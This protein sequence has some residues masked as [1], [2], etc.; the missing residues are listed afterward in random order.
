M[1]RTLRSVLWIALSVALLGVALIGA[2][3][4]RSLPVAD[5]VVELPG[6]ERNVA[7]ALD[8]FG[9]P[10][11]TAAGRTDAYRALGFMHA[12]DRLF[13]MD[14]A[15]RKSSGEL[16][17]LFGERALAMD[18][19]QRV[20][21]ARTAAAAILAA[22]P[23]DQRVILEAYA[24]GVNGLMAGSAAWPPE[25][26][27]LGYRPRPWRP[28]DSLL[29]GFGMFQTLT[30]QEQDER[31]LSVM[32]RTLPRDVLEFLTPDT[33][34]YA[35]PLVGGSGSRRPARP[36]PLESLAMLAAE[37][38]TNQR[39]AA[40]TA[41]RPALGSNQWAVSGRKTPD[42]R[43][44][45]AN[46]MHLS[47][48]LPNTW[49]R[50]D[51]RYGDARLA[52]VT[53]PGLPLVIAGSNGAVAWGFTNVDADVMDLIRIEPDRAERDAYRTRSGPLRFTARTETIR[54]R[55]AKPVEIALRRTIW[56]PVLPTPLLGA[57]VALRWTAL[58]PAGVNLGLLDMDRVATLEGAMKVLN[59]S[60]IP[61]QNVV[62]ADRRG[63]IGWTYAG[64]FP[65]R[66]GY[67]GSVAENWA[68]GTRRW[69]GFISP[70]ALPR[71]V[72]PPRGFIATA[73]NR[74]LGRGYPYTIG[75]NFSH[76]YR[77]Y[78]IAERLAELSSVAEDDLL[79]LQLDTRS[80]FFEFYRQLVL[81]LS[82]GPERLVSGDLADAR[83]S[84]EA[85]DGRL[86]AE[87]RGI[88][89][90]V[91]FRRRLVETVF[92]LWLQ[93]C[94]AADAGFSYAW[95]ELETPLRALLQQRPASVVPDRLHASWRDFLTA[96][97][98]STVRQLRADYRVEQLSALTWDRVNDVEVGH[99]LG[100]VVPLLSPLLDMPTVGS[101]GCSS[102]CV[103]VLSGAV[104]ASERFV[105]SPGH[106]ADALFHM[107]GGQSGHP[108]SAHYRDQHR[109]WLE[110]QPLPFDAGTAEHRL[111]L[112][113]APPR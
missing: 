105:V 103:R 71:L 84:A 85:W 32:Q 72:D 29:V 54:V 57:D 67:D 104:G 39:H 47:L 113:P 80:E 64:V 43:A 89:L 59:R 95:R 83:R 93:R 91:R 52:G 11:I 92:A 58:E 88:A 2:W 90:L 30:T 100:K 73:N 44:I 37:P 17:E 101:S 26:Q 3:L 69:D 76:G 106:H 28:E 41:E 13:Q 86:D 56:G 5:G 15:R 61:P 77:A 96:E 42:G 107:P 34:D 94:V 70:E 55:G 87:S 1:H 14:L 7:I 16:A 12:R 65:K 38:R 74:T 99:P 60:G 40:I 62:L 22:L 27:A 6:V 48:G 4:Y 108:L 81:D 18:R 63:R 109:A 24:E 31:M 98:I 78:R 51:L 20:Y 36:I 33:D 10:V 21:Q 112:V 35:T 8:R 111:T 79:R 102:H 9:I 68:D 53:L 66:R 97:L 45:V 50:A 110:G 25:I 46:D 19:R 75:H 23:P 49:Y 82:Q